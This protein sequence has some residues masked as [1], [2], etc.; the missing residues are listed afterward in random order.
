[1]NPLKEFRAAHKLTVR[2]VANE[3]GVTERTITAWE[4]GLFTPSNPRMSSI[5]HIMGIDF[6]LLETEWD[7]WRASLE[8]S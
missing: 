5:A 6:H 3:L 1:M 8:N 2:R 4:T 7:W